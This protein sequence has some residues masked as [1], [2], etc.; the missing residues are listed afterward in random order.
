[1]MLIG[2]A[3]WYVMIGVFAWMT[4]PVAGFAALFLAGLAQTFGMVSMGTL[5]LRATEARYRGRVMGLRMMAIYGVPLG[6]LLSGPLIRACG[7]PVTASLYSV[8][9]LACIGLVALRWRAE[10]WGLDASANRR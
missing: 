9:G 4:T 5:M 1:M 7:Y 10:L 2:C 6:L 3:L 8:F